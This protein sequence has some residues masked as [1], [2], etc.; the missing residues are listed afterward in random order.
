[1]SLF[2]SSAACASSFFHLSLSLSLSS[3]LSS[4]SHLHLQT[5]T[6]SPLLTASPSLCQANRG[7]GNCLKSRRITPTP[8]TVTPPTFQSRAQQP[9]VPHNDRAAEVGF[10]ISDGVLCLLEQHR[11]PLSVLLVVLRSQLSSGK[12]SLVLHSR[13]KNAPSPCLCI[14]VRLSSTTL[15]SMTPLRVGQLFIFSDRSFVIV[16][17]RW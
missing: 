6:Q 14:P 9:L 12:S 5:R 3:S 10:T 2:L 17:D 16:F 7:F 1:M 15:I 11:Q 8:T 13:L 4:S